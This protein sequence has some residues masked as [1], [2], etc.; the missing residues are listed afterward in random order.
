[1]R[2]RGTAALAPEG[3]RPPRT[4]WRAAA[5]EGRAVPGASRGASPTFGGGRLLLA[6]EVR[7]RGGLAG[8]ARAAA[9]T[10]S[11]GGGEPLTARGRAAAGRC[12]GA[13]QEREEVSCGAVPPPREA[14]VGASGGCRC[15][16]PEAAWARSEGW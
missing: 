15:C 4:L 12:A 2:G 7:G 11:A 10:A 13:P 3:P 8:G 1:M 14:A 9:L 5:L 6:R 16:L